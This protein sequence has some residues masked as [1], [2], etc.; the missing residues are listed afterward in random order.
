MV[1]F[2]LSLHSFLEVWSSESALPCVD[3]ECALSSLVVPATA[4]GALLLSPKSKRTMRE[5]EEQRSSRFYKE[6]TSK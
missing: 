1:D 2:P 4:M 6:R 5:Q 3:V